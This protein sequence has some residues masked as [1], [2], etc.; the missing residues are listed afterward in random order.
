MEKTNNTSI[1]IDAIV[2]SPSKEAN[3]R[4]GAGFSLGEIKSAGINIQRI[5]NLGVRVDFFRESVHNSNIQLLKDLKVSEKKDK[6]RAPF[7][8]SEKKIRVRDKKV[9]KK[10]K[11]VK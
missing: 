10:V 8:H 2:K 11:P 6:K 4:K 1:Q 7:V 3:L 9:K 5:K